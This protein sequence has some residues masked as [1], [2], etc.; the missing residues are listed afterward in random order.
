MTLHTT[1]TERAVI[2]MLLAAGAW[3]VWTMTGIT[4][5]FCISFED[6]DLWFG[7]DA[8]RVVDNL[9][10]R[11]GSH[12]RTGVHPLFSLFGLPVT[13]L[14]ALRIVGEPY[15]LVRLF[16]VAGGVAWMLAV[17]VLLRLSTGRFSAALAYSLLAY[18]S[19]SAL[20]WTVVPETYVFGSLSLVIVL[21]G[22]MV[23]ECRRVSDAWLV[24]LSAVSLF[25]T[26]TNWLGGVVLTVLHRGWKR[27]GLLS[28][29]ALATV[30][31]LWLV[32]SLVFTDTTYFF[33]PQRLMEEVGNVDAVRSGGPLVTSRS[34]LLNTMVA[35]VPVARTD[36]LPSRFDAVTMQGA[37]LAG[38][39]ALPMLLR[40]G[41]FL[42]FLTGFVR[43]VRDG[44]RVVRLLLVMLAGQF[45]LHLFYGHETFLYSLHFLPLLVMT[46]AHACRWH[47]R[48]GITFAIVL[49]AGNALHNARMLQHA[50]SLV[51]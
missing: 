26:T 46:A 30:S 48:I 37:D 32:Q 19:A 51:F 13:S 24:I 25:V 7:A 5:P 29:I 47:H 8:P 27:A 21:I 3:Y 43:V 31:L 18:S 28:A 35:G 4:R 17:Y 15:Q 42:L 14:A 16:F 20:F 33:A 9:L 36:S 12:Y 23:F 45:L 39:G 49:A 44:G 10:R 6:F 34:F 1:A 38:G 22:S 50:F 2:A 41:W 11:Y 40:A